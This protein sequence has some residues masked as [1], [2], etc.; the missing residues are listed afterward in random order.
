[1]KGRE[2]VG[3]KVKDRRPVSKAS[4]DKVDEEKKGRLRAS[5]TY[6]SKRTKFQ[7]KERELR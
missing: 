6:P 2:G 3:G 4:K 5:H 1:M 7:K